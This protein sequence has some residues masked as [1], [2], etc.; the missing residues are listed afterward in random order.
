[1]EFLRP[2]IR[3]RAFSGLMTLLILCFSAITQATTIDISYHFTQLIEFS[4]NTNFHATEFDFQVT[5]A[6]LGLNAYDTFGYCAELGQSVSAGSFTDYSLVGLNTLNDDNYYQ[7]AWLIEQFAPDA[8]NNPSLAEQ[9]QA[10]AVQGGIWI[11]LDKPGTSITNTNDISTNYQNYQNALSS[12]TMTDSLKLYLSS[13]YMLASSSTYQD[14]LLRVD[15]NPEVPEPAT[16]LLF[17]TG[18]CG[19]AIIRKKRSA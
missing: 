13:R 9:Y 8:G 5:D 19:L 12:L 14:L 16:M 7:A 1:M 10:S 2:N 18:I 17:A 11:L 6:S 15:N 4:D 3:K